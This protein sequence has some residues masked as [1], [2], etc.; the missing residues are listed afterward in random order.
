MAVCGPH[1]NREAELGVPVFD[2]A[3]GRNVSPIQDAAAILAVGRVYRRFRPDLIHAH[4]SQAGVI[5]RLA[6]AARPGTPLIHTPHQYAFVNYFAGARQQRIYRAIERSLMP[7]ATRVLCVCEDER[8]LACEVGAG[9]RAVVVYNGVDSLEPAPLSPALAG[10]AEGCRLIV[11]V[12]ELHE[13][14]GVATLIEALDLLR[15]ERPDA[16]L[17]VA[18]EGPERTALERL[19]AERGLGDAVLLAGHVDGVAGPIG[20][21]AVF[22]NP[23]WAEAFPYAVLEAMSLAAPAVVT[24]VG[25][26][27]EAVEDGRSG[28][29]IRPRDPRAMAEAVGRLLDDRELAASLGTAARERVLQ[30]FTRAQMIE[31]TLALYAEVGLQPVR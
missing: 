18:G 2:V 21:A 12:A 31:G 13:R 17:I 10:F 30:R 4:G 25:G 8:R 3:M 19:V 6:R 20:A 7:L 26:T 15:R 5:A 1:G 14:K 28:F 23:A 22:V 29:V 16:R 11:A 9:D 24:D 27:A